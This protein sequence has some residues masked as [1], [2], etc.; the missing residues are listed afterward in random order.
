MASAGPRF[1]FYYALA[2]IPL[3]VAGVLGPDVLHLSDR[4]KVVS[5]CV[6]LA[7]AVLCVLIGAFKELK[8]EASETPRTGHSRRMVAVVGMAISAL[9]FFGF[10]GAYFWPMSETALNSVAHSSDALQVPTTQPNATPP[11][12]AIA[13]PAP[14]TIAAP[15]GITLHDLFLD[16][17]QVGSYK[18]IM[19]LSTPLYKEGRNIGRFPFEMGVNGDF[20]AKSV[21][22]SLYAPGSEHAFEL[23]YWFSGA[24]K[25]FLYDLKKNTLIWTASPGTQNQYL[26]NNLMFTGKIYV[27]CENILSTEQ[28]RE[29]TDRYAKEGVEIEFR[30]FNYLDYRKKVGPPLSS[31]FGKV[32]QPT[33][34]HSTPWHTFTPDPTNQKQP[35]LMTLFMWEFQPEH[36]FTAI[37]KNK[38]SMH[39]DEDNITQDV[40]M[41]H[42]VY[43]D[44]PRRTISVVIYVPPSPYTTNLILWSIPQIKDWIDAAAKL[45]GKREELDK[46]KPCDKVYLYNE[47]E[48]TD[49]ALVSEITRALDAA[50]FTYEFRSQDYLA[51]Y[52]YQVDTKARPMPPLYQWIGEMPSLVPGQKVPHPPIWTETLPTPSPP[53][54]ALPG[55]AVGK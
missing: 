55:K 1:G 16:D 47:L 5:F 45:A 50:G 36:G 2:G 30:S 49:P 20:E 35:T 34:G 42:A 14:S 10:F 32:V 23:I 19:G 8:A 13:N 43:Y 41:L 17:F 53:F 11:P 7:L 27:Y 52:Q 22:V 6:C 39:F 37:T 28:V 18:V 26:S 12:A 40:N 24:Y 15:A 48:I 33:P 4:S 25:D 3:M 31:N 51:M 9:A 29:L 46:Y 44:R 38:V 21:F 54:P